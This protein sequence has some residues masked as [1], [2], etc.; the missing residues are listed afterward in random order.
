MVQAELLKKGIPPRMGYAFARSAAREILKWT[1]T[2]VGTA[3]FGSS[4][5][6]RF[7]VCWGVGN[8][9]RVLTSN[10]NSFFHTADG[11][12]L[13]TAVVIDLKQIARRLRKAAGQARLASGR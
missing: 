7:L 3:L 12:E 10:L 6:P 1:N 4:K 2:K 13:G 5:T 8:R 9:K 11:K